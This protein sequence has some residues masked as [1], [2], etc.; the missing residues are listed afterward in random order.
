ML[1]ALVIAA[2]LSFSPEPAARWRLLAGLLTATLAWHP[3]RTV[4]FQA[5]PA[6]IRRFEWTAEGT[7]TVVQGNGL[8]RKVW[9]HPASGAMGPWLL[10]VWT[11]SPAPFARRRYALIL[12]SRAISNAD[13]TAFRALRGRLKLTPKPTQE[14]ARRGH[15]G[16]GRP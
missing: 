9:L 11:D 13:A 1:F 8:R 6:A 5:G 15:P 16:P 14:P 12:A 4:I 7:W 2:A 10:L 3:L